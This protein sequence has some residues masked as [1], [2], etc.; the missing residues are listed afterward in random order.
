VLGI[1]GTDGVVPIY[2]PADRWSVWN[3]DEIWQGG[4]GTG[5]YVPKVNDMVIDI[6]RPYYSTFVVNSIDPVTLLPSLEPLRFNKV[7]DTLTPTDI[8]FG[9]GPGTPSDTYRLYLD[10][11]VYPHVLAVDAR[12]KIMGTMSKY[13][14]IFHGVDA[15]NEDS[16]ISRMYDASG[17]FLTDQVVLELV[18]LDHVTNYAVRCVSVCQTHKSMPD[19]ELAMVVCYSDAGHVISKRQLIVENTSFIRSVHADEKYIT[20]IGLE[21][22][23]FSPTEERVIAFPLNV[24]VS[25][26]AP[27]GVVYYSTGETARMPVDGTKFA[28]YG[29]DQYLSTIIGQ[30][31]ELV[32]SYRLSPNEVTYR[33][34]GGD[35]KFITEPYTIQTINP[36]HSYTVKLLVYPEWV[37]AFV[38]YRLRWYLYTL[39]RNIYFDVTN[40]VVYTDSTGAFDPVG[41]GYIQHKTMSINLRDVS[42][43]FKPFVHV[44]SVDITLKGPPNGY[45]VPWLV[46]TAPGT[47][48]APYGDEVHL[49]RQFN[50]GPPGSPT[51][52]KVGTIDTAYEAWLER[53][54]YRI[55]PLY[56]PEL[57]LKAPEPTHFELIDGVNRQTV[58]V[59]AW[60]Q[61]I[62]L[63]W[64][65]NEYATFRI[66][67]YKE[68]PGGPIELATTAALLVT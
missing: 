38:G 21:C 40:L 5:K 27:M 18:A 45:A 13:A 12:L 67:W 15:A 53:W 22:P 30:K 9:T 41:Y 66:R 63:T 1:V 48:L 29:L 28:L 32:L 20:H 35:G 7:D 47:G 36:N 37:S 64:V 25:A 42:P 14:K 61:P 60:N 54:Y 3:I 31:Y 44:Q 52:L 16:V 51:I 56:D 2:R 23:F 49:Y 62:V 43:S 24:P 33:A 57:E 58:S 10:T 4:I 19:G 50:P 55:Y 26:L 68:S 59:D 6:T 8:L 46:Q 34:T 11:S 39:D 17:S 65:A